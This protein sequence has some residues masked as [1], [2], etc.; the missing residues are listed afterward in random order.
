MRIVRTEHY[1]RS[2]RNAPREMQERARKAI[3]L[4]AENIRHPSLRSKIVDP[5]KRIWQARVNG[6]WRLYFQFREGECY[7]LEI[8]SHP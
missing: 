8:T 5:R 3:A 6:G 4:L 7:L 1:K 2:Y